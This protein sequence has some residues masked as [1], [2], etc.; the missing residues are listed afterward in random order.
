MAVWGTDLYLDR[1]GGMWVLTV[2]IFPSLPSLKLGDHTITVSQVAVLMKVYC[3]GNTLI[4]MKTHL[5]AAPF[6]VL[7]GNSS[8]S[9]FSTS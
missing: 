6:L 3:L 9:L 7:K 8:L 2:V 5:P 4:G 1:V